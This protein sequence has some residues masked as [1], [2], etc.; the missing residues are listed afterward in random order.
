MSRYALEWAK[1]QRPATAEA[2]V[3]LLVLGDYAEGF[4]HESTLTEVRLADDTGIDRERVADVL[5]ALEADGLAVAAIIPRSTAQTNTVRA[6]HAYAADAW[7]DNWCI[8]LL[9]P[10]IWR[11]RHCRSHGPSH[12]TYARRTAVYRLYNK[13]GALLYVGISDRPEKRFKQHRR[14]QPWWPE[15]VTREIEWRDD[16]YAAEVEEFRAIGAENPI[17][18]VQHAPGRSSQ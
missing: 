18:N 16:R 10:H 7:G 2:K 6:I 1:E 13:A 14:Y 4:N 15:V 11:G 17:Y 8:R 3:L 12:V 9:I 5:K